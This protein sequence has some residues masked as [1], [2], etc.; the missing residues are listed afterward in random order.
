MQAWSH[1]D[2]QSIRFAVGQIPSR[3]PGARPVSVPQIW[4]R[5]KPAGTFD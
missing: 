3:G 5:G 2:T 4:Q 1:D